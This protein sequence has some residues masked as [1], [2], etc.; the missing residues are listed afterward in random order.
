M[1]TSHIPFHI[2]LDHLH[3]PVKF[4]VKYNRVFQQL[5]LIELNRRASFEGTNQN[6]QVLNGHFYQEEHYRVLYHDEHNL[7]TDQRTAQNQD[8]YHRRSV[9]RPQT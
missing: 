7:I 1:T 5:F 4:L 3:S 2:F 6:H 8:M 9:R